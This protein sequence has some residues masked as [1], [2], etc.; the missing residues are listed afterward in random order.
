[1]EVFVIAKARAD[2]RRR[3]VIERAYTTAA[4][5][6]AAFCGKLQPMSTFLPSDK[7]K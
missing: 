4:M 3:D 1:M 7:T 2:V 6:G 5:S